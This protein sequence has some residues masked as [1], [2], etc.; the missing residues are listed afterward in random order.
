MCASV[1]TPSGIHMANR[2]T[3]S[4]FLSPCAHRHACHS[5]A[6]SATSLPLM[7]HVWVLMAMQVIRTNTKIQKPAGILWHKLSRQ[8]LSQVQ[9]D[10][11]KGSGMHACARNQAMAVNWPCQPCAS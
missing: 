3:M 4:A 1:R 5:I 11:F 9:R 8:K 6:I 7:C 2:V 10:L